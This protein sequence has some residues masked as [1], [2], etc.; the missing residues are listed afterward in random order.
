MLTAS[1][2]KLFSFLKIGKNQKDA[3]NWQKRVQ[4]FNFYSVG[5]PENDGSVKGVQNVSGMVRN[6][7]LN[8]L[9]LIRKISGAPGS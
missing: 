6:D 4:L 1:K 9:E 3:V 5:R 2:T 7:F 8:P